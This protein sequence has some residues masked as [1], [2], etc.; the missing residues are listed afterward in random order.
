MRRRPS[1]RLQLLTIES[2]LE[3]HRPLISRFPRAEGR[4]GGGG[5]LE[6]TRANI[7]REVEMIEGSSRDLPQEY[8][9]KLE[10]KLQEFDFQNLFCEKLKLVN[11][12][13]HLSSLFG[14]D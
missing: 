12:L 11:V 10:L 9:K 13:Q 5:G 14:N 7:Q 6:I 1:P 4:G 8:R 3:M 2:V